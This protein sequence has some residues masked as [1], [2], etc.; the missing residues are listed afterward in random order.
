MDASDSLSEDLFPDLV[1]GRC[2]RRAE[3]AY[4][5]RWRGLVAGVDEAGRGP[6]A[7]PVVTAA[8][9]LTDADLPDGLTDS[10]ELDAATRERLFAIICRDHHVSVA[11]ASA[12]RIDLM[13]IRAA[14][15]W[16]MT[17]AL[18]HLPVRPVGVLVDGRDVPAEVRARGFQGAAIVKG[19]GCVAAIAA[20]SIVA[21]VTRDRMMA[22]YANRF[23]A[24]GFERH[25]GY[26]TPEHKRLLKAHGPCPL[27]RR[28]FAPVRELLGEPAEAAE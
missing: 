9:V 18:V 1:I 2:D 21:K 15:L 12:A 22:A 5:R 27:H 19:D 8:V 10:K 28:S 25:M 26:G 24:Y 4:G 7:G 23:D 11:S 3:E 17:R 14:T 13:N 16:A 20:A 6:L